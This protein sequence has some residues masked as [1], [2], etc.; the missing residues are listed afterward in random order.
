M[1]STALNW[2]PV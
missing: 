1:K 2:H